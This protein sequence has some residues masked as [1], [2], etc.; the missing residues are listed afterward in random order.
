VALLDRWHPPGK[1][2]MRVRNVRLGTVL[3][4]A[5]PQ[6]RLSCLI[7][8]EAF[9]ITSRTRAQDRDRLVTRAYHRKIIQFLVDNA[10]VTEEV[11]EPEAAQEPETPVDESG[12]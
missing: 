8:D 12:E 9:I 11:V 3:R 5:L 2:T 7:K 10:K 6:M 1:V 4:A